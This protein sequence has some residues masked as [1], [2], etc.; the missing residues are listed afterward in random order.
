M[1][2]NHDSD[3]N[4]EQTL[5]TLEQLSQTLEV[6][7]SVVDRLKLHLNRQLSLNAELFQDQEQREALER[8]ERARGSQELEEESFVVE[9]TQAELED[10]VDPTLH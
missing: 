7:G 8:E 10:G 2:D 6:M 1:A 9:I 3:Q 5:Q 4:L